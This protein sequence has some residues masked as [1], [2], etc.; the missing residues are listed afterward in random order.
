MEQQE[1]ATLE[2]AGAVAKT[3]AAADSVTTR[4]TRVSDEAAASGLR[5]SRVRDVTGEV[6]EAVRELRMGIVRSVRGARSEVDRRASLRLDGAW[7]ARLVTPA[8]SG[9]LAVTVV[10]LS[11][12]GFALSAPVAG[13]R[14]GQR[15]T[16]RLDALLPGRDLPGEALHL[17]VGERIDPL[18]GGARV[19]AHQPGAPGLDAG[20]EPHEAVAR[21]RPRRHEEAARR[22]QLAAG[23]PGGCE[24]RA[25]GDKWARARRQRE[26]H[27][28]QRPPT[29]PVRPAPSHRERRGRP[30][31]PPPPAP[32]S[33]HPSAPDTT[34][35]PSQV[36]PCPAGG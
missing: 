12:G 16:L 17:V 6:E 3:A 15:V 22:L 36:P 32:P 11:E 31:R 27:R 18:A 35:P 20:L 34:P 2:I 5:A 19:D 28:A 23:G 33:P 7:A 24:R 25:G 9:G 26:R 1:A 29:T 8:A 21:E 10:D 30:T 4:I 14:V 13:V